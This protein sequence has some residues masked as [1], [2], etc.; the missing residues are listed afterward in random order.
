[1]LAIKKAQEFYYSKN[2]TYKNT[3]LDRLKQSFD[4]KIECLNVLNEMD[5]TIANAKKTAKIKPFKPILFA[6]ISKGN[7]TQQIHVPDAHLVDMIVVAQFK[8]YHDD[9]KKIREHLYNA[10]FGSD[11]VAVLKLL[12]D[13]QKIS[14]ENEMQLKETLN[15]DV[16]RAEAA[17]EMLKKTKNNFNFS[18]YN[19]DLSKSIKEIISKQFDKTRQ[20]YTTK[21]EAWQKETL[22]MLDTMRKCDQT[23][24]NIEVINSEIVE[25]KDAFRSL[26]NLLFD[27]KMKVEQLPHDVNVVGEIVQLKFSTGS[28]V[29]NTA[30]K[31]E[32]FGAIRFIYRDL[33]EMKQ[34]LDLWYD[35]LV[36]MGAMKVDNMDDDDDNS[37]HKKLHLDSFTRA[38]FK[39]DIAGEFIFP[40][41]Q[42]IDEL[43]QRQNE[44]CKIIKSSIA[45]ID[46]M[47]VKD[48]L[49]KMKTV[50]NNKNNGTQ[51]LDVYEETVTDLKDLNDKTEDYCIEYEDMENK[52]R[53]TV[54]RK[55]FSLFKKRTKEARIYPETC[56]NEITEGF[57]TPLRNGYNDLTNLLLKVRYALDE[58]VNGQLQKDF[59]KAFGKQIN[60]TYQEPIKPKKGVS[61][62]TPK[63]K[64][65]AFL[66]EHIYLWNEQKQPI[67]K[68]LI[69]VKNIVKKFSHIRDSL[70]IL[71]N[72]LISFTAVDISTEKVYPDSVSY[73]F[74]KTRRN[75]VLLFNSLPD[76]LEALLCSFLI[77]ANESGLNSTDKKIVHPYSKLVEELNEMH[78][79]LDDRRFGVATERLK[80]S[81]IF[82]RKTVMDI[83]TSSE[84]AKFKKFDEA[85]G[86]LQKHVNNIGAAYSDLLSIVDDV[87]AFVDEAVKKITIFDKT[88]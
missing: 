11:Y 74:I 1:M 43:Q 23:L 7:S 82:I 12:G 56:P 36:E 54:L 79:K 9:V 20:F 57:V 18:F 44:F 45:T 50:N 85:K 81:Y 66:D 53:I 21:N 46:E 37:N 30:E 52:N 65:T 47:N 55:D 41:D 2:P 70:N 27:S 77:I 59:M 58:S 14:S 3:W 78:L 73:Q 86:N 10:Y 24:K 72:S 67:Q 33:F 8:S 6:T 75:D 4:K 88:T 68:T 39:N 71:S 60:E 22:E 76:R 17:F 16:K 34:D 64:F 61:I 80:R 29:L 26:T 63:A 84:E 38:T 40:S 19:K 42:I 69:K 35:I 31:R 28:D 49:A 83:R 5:K 32:A 13:Q 87:N 25:F 51:L 15:A 48:F 62:L